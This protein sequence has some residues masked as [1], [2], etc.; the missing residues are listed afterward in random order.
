M[1]GPYLLKIL[2][3]KEFQNIIIVKSVT[4]FVFTLF[5]A[6]EIS[7]HT[8]KQIKRLYDDLYSFDYDQFRPI[9]F[10]FNVIHNIYTVLKNY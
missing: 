9:Y 10:M 5:Q 7:T 1:L 4:I 3:F 2:I 8:K 6:E